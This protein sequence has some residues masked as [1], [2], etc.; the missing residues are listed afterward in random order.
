MEEV[1]Y[2]NVQGINYIVF[3]KETRFNKLWPIHTT[4]NLYVAI[5]YVFQ[6]YL[7]TWEK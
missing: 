6:E 5:K 1:S 7:M 4:E 2:E 3:L